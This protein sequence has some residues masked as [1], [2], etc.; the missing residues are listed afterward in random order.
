[1][2][3]DP[4]AVERVPQK[5]AFDSK[6]FYRLKGLDCF[7]EVH[8]LLAHGYHP[9][10]VAAMVQNQYGE[11]KEIQQ[12][13]LEKLLRSYYEDCIPSSEKVANQLPKKFDETVRDFE[14]NI[15]VL[16]EYGNLFKIQKQ[17][18]EMAWESEQQ[19][20]QLM[21]ITG[22]EIKVAADLLDK[23]KKI[24]DEK[25]LGVGTIDA[26]HQEAG[27]ALQVEKISGVSGR[28]LMDASARNSVIGFLDALQSAD[29]RVVEATL[30]A[31]EDE[32]VIDVDSEESDDEDE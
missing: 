31:T 26:M 3:D 19:T 12:A 4:V 29:P 10:K 20:E 27:M 5:S 25:G 2:S 13:S 32:D 11:Y 21:K 15:E 6:K 23:I 9:S 30:A 28:F 22:R 14:E 8:K 24:Q 17:R 18:I 7:P 16:K 1:M